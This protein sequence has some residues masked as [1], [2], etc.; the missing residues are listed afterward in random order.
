MKTQHT[1]HILVI[2]KV[3]LR[4]HTSKP[5]CKYFN[6]NT[7][8]LMHITTSKLLIDASVLYEVCIFVK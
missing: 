2:W 7:R 3:S 5:K 1:E 6:T 8:T 4:V